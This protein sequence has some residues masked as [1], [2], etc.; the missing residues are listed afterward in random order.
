MGLEKEQTFLKWP[1]AGFT[2]KVTGVETFFEN[3][4]RSL[5]YFVANNSVYKIY[6]KY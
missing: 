3:N 2:K 4:E 6:R 1:Q 5:L